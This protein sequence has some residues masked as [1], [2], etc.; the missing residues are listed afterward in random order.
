[1]DVMQYI[2]LTI[3]WISII[4]VFLPFVRNDY[5]IFRILEYP[6]LQK[7][8]ICVTILILLLLFVDYNN[9]FAIA[10]IIALGGAVF[11]LARKI[12][13]YTIL[14]KKQMVTI[15]G[16]NINN[17]LKLF[18]ANV[19]QYNRTY[20]KMLEQIASCKPDI[21]LLVETDKLWEDAMDYIIKDF[22]HC[23]K[24]PL[25]NTYGMLLYSKLEIKSGSVKYLVED[26]VP[27]IE[28]VFVL[29]SGQLIKAFCLHPKPPVPGEDSHSTA[30]DKEIM[31][32]GIKVKKEKMPVIVMGDLNDVAWSYVTELFTK[33]SGLLDP[34]K[35]RGFYSTFS[36]KHRFMRFPLD[37]VFC[38]NDFGLISMQ[39]LEY[40]GSD[41]FPMFIHFEYQPALKK[42]Q[43]KPKPDSDD[44]EEAKEKASQPVE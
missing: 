31:Q 41:H 9:R 24:Q 14:A 21:V 4:A 44:V 6:R 36:A 25:D 42:V 7:F 32:V 28:A 40:N 10:T 27:S 34:R 26:D 37:Y 3:G 30:K 5:W 8:V 11:Y 20:N 13:P 22:P 16:Q 19:Y 1:M 12:R 18:T 29:P 23:I 2:L 15:Q 43:H 17:Q 35:G 39:R 38:S 33:T